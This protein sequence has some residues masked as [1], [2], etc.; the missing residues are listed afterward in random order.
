MTLPRL[1]GIAIL[2][3]FILGIALTGTASAAAHITYSGN[4]R[5]PISSGE[6]QTETAGG[7]SFFCTGDLGSGKLGANP[8]T[9][10]ELTISLVGCELDGFP[11]TSSGGKSGLIDFVKLI[12]TLGDINETTA[13]ALLK[14]AS[15]TSF[16]VPAKCGTIAYE[17][18][19]SV[20]GEFKSTQNDKNTK[21]L[22]L[23]F[24]QSKGIQAIKKFEGEANES[25]LEIN[26]G[27][28]FEKAGLESTETLTLEGTGAGQLLP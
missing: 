8:A 16:V 19:G 7:L 13:G 23:T 9:T 2:A 15:G 3:T 27:K 12:A 10:V 5:F 11:C 21:A 1:A 17:L 26:L 22:T 24:A 28:G 4:G 6:Q 14:P 18:K 25:T 20:I